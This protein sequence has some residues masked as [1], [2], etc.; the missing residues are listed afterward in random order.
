MALNYTRE[1]SRWILGKIYSLNMLPREVVVSPSLEV[2][3]NC[4]D[5]ALKDMVS[6]HGGGWTDA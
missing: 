1:S 3:R 6:G 2:F 4:G 5:V